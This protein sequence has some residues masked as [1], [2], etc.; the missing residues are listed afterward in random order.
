MTKKVKLVQATVIW[1]D[2]AAQDGPV[3]PS[4]FTKYVHLVSTGMLVAKDR[5]EITLAQDYDPNDQQ[6]RKVI[7][8]PRGM[9]KK[10]ITSRI[11]L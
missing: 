4:E 6:Y 11:T 8:I 1:H 9:V 2:A 10:V 3:V 5:Q 7:H